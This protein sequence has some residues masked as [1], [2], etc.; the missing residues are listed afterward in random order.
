MS[1]KFCSFPGC[2][3]G[4]HWCAQ[5]KKQRAE[6]PLYQAALRVLLGDPSDGAP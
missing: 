6:A 4:C 5:G 1:E 2:T 3:G